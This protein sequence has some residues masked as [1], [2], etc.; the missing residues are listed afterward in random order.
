MESKSRKTMIFAISAIEP[1]WLDLPRLESCL[2]LGGLLISIRKRLYEFGGIMPGESKLFRF[3]CPTC[4]ANSPVLV[5]SEFH[6]RCD[7]AKVT[8]YQSSSRL[9][10]VFDQE[11]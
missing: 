3:L 8:L 10:L 5:R 2:S 6:W 4:R 7:H 11:S 1:I 9:Y